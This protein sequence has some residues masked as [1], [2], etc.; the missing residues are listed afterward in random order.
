[1]KTVFVGLSGGVD[2]AV[3]AYLLKQ[4]GYNVV[5]AF[6]KGWEPDFLPCTGTAD[7]LSAMRVAAHLEIPFVTYDVSE[8]YKKHV[9]DYFIAEYQ[10]GRTPNPDV[11]CNREIKFGVFWERAK[12]DGA[13][14]IATGHY[15]S[16][17]GAELLVS[18]DPSKDQTYFLWT[19]TKD[20]LEHTLFPIG[21]YK[22]SEVRKIAEKIKLPN[23]I[24]PDSQG[25]CFLGHVD[26]HG[27]LKRYLPA[28]QGYIYT[29]DRTKIGEHDG[30]WFY[31]LGQHVSLGG[32]AER[33]YV[34]AKDTEK[35]E[36]IVDSAPKAHTAQKT[37]GLAA[38]SWV[39]T[40]PAEPVRAQYRYHGEVIPAV[41]EGGRLTFS[42]PVLVAAG[43]SVVLYSVDMKQCVGGGIITEW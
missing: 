15:A 7:R 1:V 37:Y 3:A 9:V 8:E 36:L 35:N 42:T 17:N 25:L 11:V 39:T 21:T 18:A 24:R 29:T 6:I 26:M 30:V 12:K 41:Y 22:K 20:D 23:A 16:T 28:K 33:L 2:S 38:V 19:L 40:E 13:D 14:C 34:V 10:A 4:E 27:F 43:Q 5:G 32:T 31:T